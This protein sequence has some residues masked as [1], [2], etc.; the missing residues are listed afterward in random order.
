[1]VYEYANDS[2]CDRHIMML[3]NVD[4]IEEKLRADLSAELIW[5]FGSVALRLSSERS[6]SLSLPIMP[7]GSHKYVLYIGFR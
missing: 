4:H 2:V 1:M 7:Y 3:G 6:L 5:G